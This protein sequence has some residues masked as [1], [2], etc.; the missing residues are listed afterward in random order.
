MKINSSSIKMLVKV[1]KQILGVYIIFWEIKF[2]YLIKILQ[3]IN[4]LKT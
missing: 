3:L 1:S 2:G 4:Y